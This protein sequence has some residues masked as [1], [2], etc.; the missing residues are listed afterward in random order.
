MVSPLIRSDWKSGVGAAGV[1]GTV[2]CAGSAAWHGARR[3][4]EAQ[5]DSVIAFNMV[6]ANLAQLAIPWHNH[7]QPNT[8]AARFIGGWVVAGLPNLRAEPSLKLMSSS[9]GCRSI[10]RRICRKANLLG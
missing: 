8:F 7:I 4:S 5:I 3:R 6:E 10:G 2:F 1:A 9:S